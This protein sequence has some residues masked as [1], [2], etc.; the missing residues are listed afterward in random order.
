MILKFFESLKESLYDIIGYILPGLFILHLLYLPFR[1]SIK[2][3]P[4]YV[5]TNRLHS[6]Q[7][8]LQGMIK[9]DSSIS[10][11]IAI[12]LIAY[13]LGHVSIF[14]SNSIS[15][16]PIIKFLV[17]SSKSKIDS[18]FDYVKFIKDEVNSKMISIHNWLAPNT[19]NNDNYFINISTGELF[20]EYSSKDLEKTNP[21]KPE[22]FILNYARAYF[23]V[24]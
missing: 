23:K 2:A 20:V 6:P 21:K 14:L 16:N 12:L 5:I 3:T 22:K 1:Y 7:D 13:L 17:K 18:D 24:H 9:V 10:Y 19:F 4:V 8:V 15:Q 11:S